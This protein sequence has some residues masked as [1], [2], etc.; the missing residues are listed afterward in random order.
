MKLTK[1]RFLLVYL[2]VP[3]VFLFAQTTEIR[4]RFG[5]VL[6]LLGESIRLWAN[7]H[8]GHLK[9]NWT[10]KWRGD[11]KVG[12]LMTGGPYAHI[13]HPL[14]FGS[15][16]IGLGV[17]VIVGRLAFTL[18]GLVLFFLV[19]RRK[20]MEEE[21]TLLDEW[22]DEYARYQ[23][24]VPRYLPTW[25]AYPH[26]PSRW[27][28]AGIMA[29]KEWKTL[30]WALVCLLVFYFREEFLQEHELFGPRNL[31]KHAVVLF[32]FIALMACDGIAELVAR[33]RRRASAGAGTAAGGGG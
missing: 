23:Q 32:L 25:R 16:V 5:A 3:L 19:Y 2:L 17:A 30:I 21:A 4:L 11:R 8:V 29:S 18:V 24:A 12:Q 14:Y 6:V 13:R 31:V 1:P 27:S 10:Q 22:P 9:V 28:W 7:G 26:P 15:L 20:I 33:S